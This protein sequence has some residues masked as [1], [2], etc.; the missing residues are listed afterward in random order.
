VLSVWVQE[1]GV[2]SQQQIGRSPD[3][4]HE[5]ETETEIE[6]E[7][8]ENGSLCVLRTWGADVYQWKKV[9]TEVG[10]FQMIV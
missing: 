3:P 2:G 1:S 6:R 9:W 8:H 4:S 7:I 10:G 5:T